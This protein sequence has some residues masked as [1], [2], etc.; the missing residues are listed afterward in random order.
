MPRRRS[1]HLPEKKKKMAAV[2][3]NRCFYTPEDK[4]AKWWIFQ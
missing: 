1:L 3:L 4:T 2:F